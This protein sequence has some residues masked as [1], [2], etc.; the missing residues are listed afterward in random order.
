MSRFTQQAAVPFQAAHKLEASIVRIAM[1]M[2]MAIQDVEDIVLHRQVT[3]TDS[4]MLVVEYMPWIGV[5]KEFAYGLSRREMS[6]KISLPEIRLQMDG[7]WFELPLDF[8]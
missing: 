1:H 7:H 5:P 6:P 8:C 2:L 4:I 3:V